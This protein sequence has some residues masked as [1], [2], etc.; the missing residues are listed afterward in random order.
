MMTNNSPSAIKNFDKI[1][2][3]YIILPLKI[4]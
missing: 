3:F 4:F 2:L 1:I